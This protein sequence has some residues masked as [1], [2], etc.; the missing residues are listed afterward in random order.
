MPT[1]TW[2]E[3]EERYGETRADLCAPDHVP[4]CA[5]CH[6]ENATTLIEFEG[7]DIHIGDYCALAIERMNA[8]GVA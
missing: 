4:E 7:K 1:M 5:L 3:Y 8:G 2:A 6:E